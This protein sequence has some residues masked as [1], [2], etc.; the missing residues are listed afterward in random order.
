VYRFASHFGGIHPPA[1]TG[2]GAYM[3]TCYRGGLMYTYRDVKNE[4]FLRIAAFPK[5]QLE[6]FYMFPKGVF[7][8]DPDHINRIQQHI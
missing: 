5:N 7:P 4:D 1:E 6:S 2:I 8:L 3:T